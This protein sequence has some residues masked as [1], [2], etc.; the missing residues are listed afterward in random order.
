VSPRARNITVRASVVLATACLVLA[1]IAGYVHRV[2]VNSD[3]FANRATAALRDDSVRSLV[4]GKI[5]DEVVLER[6]SDLLAARPLIETIASTIVGSR[7]FTSL[8]RSAV[9]DVHS[10]VF[11]RDSESVTLRVADVGTVLAAALQKL[12]PSLAAKVESTGDAQLVSRDLGTFG[13]WAPSGAISRGSPKRSASSRCSCW[14]RD[15]CS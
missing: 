13:G 7:A 15:C 6:E 9:R 11:N 5:T 1:L 3:Q 10:A 2:A 12:R 14:R 8:F 4:A